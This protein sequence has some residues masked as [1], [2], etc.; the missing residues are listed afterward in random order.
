[1]P[2]GR[3]GA[4]PAAH[5]VEHRR[6]AR[7]LEAAREQGVLL[8]ARHA[9]EPGGDG[10]Q[11]DDD[12]A[13][14]V[15]LRAARARQAGPPRGLVD[16]GGEARDRAA[17]RRGLQPERA[18]GAARLVAGAPQREQLVDALLGELR[19]A[20]AARVGDE[21]GVRRA[22]GAQDLAHALARDAEAQRDLVEAEAALAQRAHLAMRCC[23]PGAAAAPSSTAASASDARIELLA[24]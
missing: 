2:G 11:R 6:Q 19:G 24:V 23:V 20:P 14:G 8:G 10:A 4:R 9:A 15:R 18:R 17:A 22:V 3:D 12:V 7:Q 21:L 13:L 5:A 1:M 16:V